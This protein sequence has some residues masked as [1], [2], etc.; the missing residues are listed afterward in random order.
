MNQSINQ[1]IDPSVV[2]LYSYFMVPSSHS[3]SAVSAN[4]PHF[5]FNFP[6]KV[7]ANLSL[8][9]PNFDA[10][11]LLYTIPALRP[12]KTISALLILMV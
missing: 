5:D 2:F 6:R 4:T 11:R 9:P 12:F 7:A 8:G 3:S 10:M 1:S